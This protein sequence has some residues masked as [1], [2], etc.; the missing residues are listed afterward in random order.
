MSVT[1]FETPGAVRLRIALGS[2]DVRIEATDERRTEIELVALRDDEATHL[3]IDEATVK[4]QDRADGTEVVVEIPRKGSF[5][6]LG[7]LL[8]RGP[9]VGIRVRCPHGA[10]VDASSQSADI[11]T[12]GLLD[13]L[14]ARTGSGDFD[15]DEVSTLRATTASGDVAVRTI[16]GNGNVKTASGDVSVREAHGNLSLNLVSGDAIVGT[17][18]GPLSVAT[19]SGDQ[20]IAAVQSG[21]VKLQSVSGDV[22]V[23]VR[24]GLRVWIDATSVSGSMSSDLAMDGAEY[25]EGEPAIELRARTVSGD[26]RIVRA[27][28]P[29]LS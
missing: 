6:G 1:T 16:F 3:A 22:R 13:T 26:V 20:D 9:S 23:G 8:G 18:R 29:N 2:G 28:E 19:V 7:G 14:E 5:G 27:D 4:A 10:A 12:K 11:V 15:F 24:P 25:G 21:E 17:A